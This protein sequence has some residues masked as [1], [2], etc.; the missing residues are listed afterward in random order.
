MSRPPQDFGMFWNFPKYEP[1][2]VRRVYY[3]DGPWGGW[4]VDF[5]DGVGFP[6]SGLPLGMVKHHLPKALRPQFEELY[7]KAYLEEYGAEAGKFTYE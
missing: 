1:N 7:Y 4:C 2:I 3:V 6:L 5:T